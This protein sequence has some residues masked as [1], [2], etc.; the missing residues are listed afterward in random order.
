MKTVLQ[1]LSYRV[2]L[3][4]ESCVI[5]KLYP[6]VKP[7]DFQGLVSCRRSEGQVAQL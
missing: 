2:D 1:T 6:S 7:A 5:C 3:T 4:S